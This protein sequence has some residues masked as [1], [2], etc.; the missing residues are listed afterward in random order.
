MIL[1]AGGTG[2]LGGLVVEELLARGERVRVLTRSAARADGLRAAGAEVA[3]GDVRDPASL[4]PAADGAQ[5]VVSAVHGFAGTGHVTPAN[6]DRDGNAHLV[7]AAQRAG[8]EMV[9]MSVIGAAR[10]HPMELFQMKAE[11]EEALRNS[12]LRWTIVRA[13][14]FQELWQELLQKGPGRRPLIFGRGDSPIDFVRV[15]KVAGVVVEAALDPATRGQVLE[16]R[17]QS[18]FTLNQLAAQTCPDAAPMHVPRL[19]LRALAHVA[20]SPLK[21]QAA[22][23]LIM[24][25]A[26]RL[27]LREGQSR[28]V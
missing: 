27:R 23:A 17:G 8:A 21:R 4:L 6:V 2:R 7:A 22:A 28:E 9:L 25:T 15:A 20:P 3:L 12:G 11:A 18:T 26:P 14:A 13:N 16:V 10:Q 24:D 1:V 19:V 5:V